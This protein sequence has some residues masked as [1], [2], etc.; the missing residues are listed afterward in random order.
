MS[1]EDVTGA[2]TRIHAA[3]DGKGRQDSKKRAGNGI[4]V[5]LLSHAEVE[6]QDVV[7]IARSIP[8]DRL[9]ADP[10][11]TAILNG[12]LGAIDI[13]KVLVA[14]KQ[15]DLDYLVT[16]AEKKPAA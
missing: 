9:K 5:H 2:L 1:Q 3:I 6:A 4:L 15:T 12:C 16:V 10:R 11:L 13:G 7:A 14:M 8:D